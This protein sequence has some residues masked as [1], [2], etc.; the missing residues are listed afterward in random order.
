MS[1]GPIL[2][3]IK[4]IQRLFKEGEKYF[5]SAKKA[6]EEKWQ[7]PAGHPYQEPWNELDPHE[8]LSA[9]EADHYFPEERSARQSTVALGVLVTS[10][11]IVGTIFGCYVQSY[12]LIAIT[13]FLAVLAFIGTI[14]ARKGELKVATARLRLRRRQ[15]KFELAVEKGTACSNCRRGKPNNTHV[16]PVCGFNSA[17]YSAEAAAKKAART[18]VKGAAYLAARTT[19]EITKGTAKAI[20]WLVT[21]TKKRSSAKPVNPPL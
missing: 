5:D 8:M 10:L 21:P 6:D 2:A 11:F 4:I 1:F 3:S 18:V 13:G 12:W 17:I 15:A 16:C 19:W 14:D 7:T 9:S 20:W